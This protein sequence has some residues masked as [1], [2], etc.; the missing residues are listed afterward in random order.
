METKK[1]LALFLLITLTLAAPVKAAEY[2]IDADHSKVLFTIKHLGISSVSGEFQKFSGSFNFDP[3]SI[4][5]STANAKIDTSSINTSVAKR[6]EHLKSPDFLDVTKFPEMTFSSKKIT[7]VST[8][9]FKVSGD[10][11]LHGVTQ[12]VELDVKLGGL[13][14]DPWGSERAAFTAA[15]KID[16]RRFGVVWNKT[17]ETGGLVVGNDVKIRLEVE[18]IKK[19]AET[20]PSK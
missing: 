16:R 2:T 10:L 12:P 3:Q 15:A 19:A 18:G 4:E 14:K 9:R 11:T 13:V 7:P 5:A 17:L 6:D 20:A 1:L 8:K